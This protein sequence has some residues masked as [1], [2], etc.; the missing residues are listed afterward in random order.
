MK[1]TSLNAIDVDWRI[2]IILLISPPDSVSKAFLPSSETFI[3]QSL[4]NS[5]Q[6]AAASTINLHQ[7]QR[8]RKFN[9]EAPS[10]ETFNFS[11][12]CL[13]Q[14]PN[15]QQSVWWRRDF[16]KAQKLIISRPTQTWLYLSRIHFS[17][18]T[19]SRAL[20]HTPRFAGRD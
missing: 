12:L 16:H 6:S 14:F 1:L 3:L 17:N 15:I 10:F 7:F 18:F 5:V 9:S 11:A 13:A 4:W 20:A 8:W 2:F 19:T